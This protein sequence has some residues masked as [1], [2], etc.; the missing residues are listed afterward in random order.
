MF[1]A[2]CKQIKGEEKA[3]EEYI[4]IAYARRHM[5]MDEVSKY[6]LS[7]ED[8]GIEMD[9]LDLNEWD[10]DEVHAQIQDLKAAAATRQRKFNGGMEE[11]RRLGQD[12][13]EA[14]GGDKKGMAVSCAPRK[15]VFNPNDDTTGHSQK[16]ANVWKPLGSGITNDAKENR[17]RVRSRFLD[18]DKSRSYG[19]QSEYSDFEAMIL[20]L[21]VLWRAHT[22]NTGEQCAWEFIDAWF[23]D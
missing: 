1:R 20:M 19:A 8:I 21:Q 11:L 18:G 5:V 22:S 16:E 15:R 10:D 14:G 6:H 3:T 9:A 2:L 13:F 4:K 17:W 23:E 7:E 12:M